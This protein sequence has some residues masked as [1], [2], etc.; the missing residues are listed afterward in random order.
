M[1]DTVLKF[2]PDWAHCQVGDVENSVGCLSKVRIGY[3]KYI[4]EAQKSGFP[5]ESDPGKRE[6]ASQR[7][8]EDDVQVR[9]K[10]KYTCLD[11]E[12]NQLSPEDEN[13][14][15]VAGMF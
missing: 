12:E 14:F 6:V 15:I 4:S 8:R 1:L 11:Q 9:G 10:S 2:H 3:C 13:H 5:K 7:G